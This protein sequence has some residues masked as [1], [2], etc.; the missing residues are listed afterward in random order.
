MTACVVVL[1][2]IGIGGCGASDF[3]NQPRAAIPY[4]TT[5]SIG[6]KAVNISPD[7]FGAGIT[8]IT[9]A[10][11]TSDPAI[12]AIKGPTQAESGTI[13]PQ[14]VTTIK[15]TLE[16]GHYQAIAKGVTGVKP[17]TLSI[18]PARNTSQNQLLQP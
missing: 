6:A 13:Q 5:A 16:K 7:R 10:N 18:G 12:F 1:A 14:A 2:G 15:T 9:V 8:V 11:L 3:A 4:E 17:A